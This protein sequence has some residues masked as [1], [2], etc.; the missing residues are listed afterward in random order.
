[1]SY[2]KLYRVS[3]DITEVEKLLNDTN[4][5]VKKQAVEL[6]NELYM[7]DELFYTRAKAN[8]HVINEVQSLKNRFNLIAEKI[9]LKTTIDIDDNYCQCRNCGEEMWNDDTQNHN[10]DYES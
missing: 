5:A 1:M 6:T 4:E 2:K 3:S 10:C 9:D 7:Y 8:K